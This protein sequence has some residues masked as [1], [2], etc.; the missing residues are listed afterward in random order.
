MAGQCRTASSMCSSVQTEALRRLRSTVIFQ[1]ICPWWGTVVLQKEQT[2]EECF[3]QPIVSTS[4]QDYNKAWSGREDSG[5]KTW[6]NNKFYCWL[7]LGNCTV[8]I[9]LDFGDGFIT[10]GGW[11]TRATRNF[12]ESRAPVY[13]YYGGCWRGKI[14]PACLPVFLRKVG[15]ARRD[16]QHRKWMK[17]ESLYWKTP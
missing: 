12:K 14:V 1:V 10:F 16:C 11:R 5:G 8:T 13:K 9:V 2:L 17:E 4:P 7:L 15:S 3:V 6:R